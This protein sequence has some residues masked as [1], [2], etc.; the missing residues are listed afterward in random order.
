MA[1]HPAPE[2]LYPDVAARGSLR[3]ALQALADEGG[4]S[5]PFTAEDPGALTY[6]VTESRLPHRKRLLVNSWV[7][8]RRWSVRDAAMSSHRSYAPRAAAHSTVTDL[9]RFR[10]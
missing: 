1:K 7:H 3:A 9:A 2:V 5:V 4:L 8:K 10:G 6:A